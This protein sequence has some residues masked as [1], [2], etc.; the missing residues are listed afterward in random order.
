MLASFGI[1]GPLGIFD[2]DPLVFER[3]SRLTY[4]RNVGPTY[5]WRGRVMR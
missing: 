1:A 3:A 2:A 4:D 5:S